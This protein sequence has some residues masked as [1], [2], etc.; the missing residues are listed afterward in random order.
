MPLR[1]DVWTHDSCLV[2]QSVHSTEEDKNKH[3][4]DASHKKKVVVYDF[5]SRELS[6]L[7]ASNQK[8]FLYER[9]YRANASVAGLDCICEL[10]FSWSAVPLWA[11]TICY[12]AGETLESADD[13]MHSSYHKRNYICEYHPDRYA[14]LLKVQ[15]KSAKNKQ[16]LLEQEAI[17]DTL[18][19]AKGLLSPDVYVLNGRSQEWAFQKLGLS[20]EPRKDPFIAEEVTDNHKI[21]LCYVCGETF[22]SFS[23]EEEFRDAWFSHLSTS[24]HQRCKAMQ[25]LVHEDNLVECEGVPAECEL[26]TNSEFRRFDDS[27]DDEANYGPTVGLDYLIIYNGT[28]CFCSL[29]FAILPKSS[30]T[31]H[32]S[33]EYHIE[34]FFRR[35]DP[36]KLLNTQY[37]SVS[38]RHGILEFCYG[39]LKLSSHKYFRSTS[40]IPILLQKYALQQRNALVKY[41]LEEVDFG[42]NLKAVWCEECKEYVNTVGDE[43]AWS[44]H[45]FDDSHFERAARRALYHYERSVVTRSCAALDN[46][47]HSYPPTWDEQ[48]SVSLG[49]LS[50]QNRCEFGLEFIIRDTLSSKLYCTC[51]F[52]QCDDN[53]TQMFSK[54][55][56]SLEHITRAMHSMNKKNM[57]TLSWRFPN[58]NDRKPLVM[59]YLVNCRKKLRQE[60]H[61][62]SVYNPALVYKMNCS[63]ALPK[64]LFKLAKIAPNDRITFIAEHKKRGQP[65]IVPLNNALNEFCR[66]EVKLEKK[67]VIVCHCEECSQS[68]SENF[69]KLD[70]AIAEH[71]LSLSH[72]ERKEIFNDNPF[73]ESQRI[74][75]R[76]SKIKVPPYK[77]PDPKKKVTWKWNDKKACYEFVYAQLGLEDIRERR[78]FGGETTDFFCTLCAQSFKA[79]KL[80]LECH[81]RSFSH[82]FYF[83]HK[84]RPAIIPELQ[85]QITAELEVAEKHKN[86]RRLFAR[87]LKGCETENNQCGIPIYDFEGRE[88]EYLDVKRALE[89]DRETEKNSDKRPKKETPAYEIYDLNVIYK[90]NNNPKWPNGEALD[91]YLTAIIEMC[92]EKNKDNRRETIVRPLEHAKRQLLDTVHFDGMVQL[93]DGAS[94]SAAVSNAPAVTV[95]PAVEKRQTV[96]TKAPTEKTKEASTPSRSTEV[97]ATPTA[98]VRQT[99]V[100]ENVSMGTS[101][102]RDSER[103]RRTRTPSPHRRSRRHS[104]SPVH[105]RKSSRHRIPEHRRSK[106]SKS[107]S[108]K[109]TRKERRNNE[110]SERPSSSRSKSV[111]RRPISRTS[112]SPDTYESA[113]KRL[114]DLKMKLATNETPRQFFPLPPMRKQLGSQSVSGAT[115]KDP[116]PPHRGPVPFPGYINIGGVYDAG[117]LEREYPDVLRTKTTPSD[118]H[119]TTT[120]E[121][122]VVAPSTDLTV[123]A[124]SSE[125]DRNVETTN[126][127]GASEDIRN[128]LM[129]RLKK[130]ANK[131]YKKIVMNIPKDLPA[132]KQQ[133]LMRQQTEKLKSNSPTKKADKKVAKTATLQQRQT[134]EQQE[135]ERLQTISPEPDDVIEVHSQQQ[136]QQQTGNGP[137]RQQQ[138]QRQQQIKTVNDLSK[139]KWDWVSGKFVPDNSTAVSQSAN[140]PLTNVP[141]ISPATAPPQGMPIP[142]IGLIAAPKLVETSTQQ[143]QN[144][145][146]QLGMST[147]A[148]RVFSGQ[149]PMA[150]AHAPISTPTV[151]MFRPPIPTVTVANLLGQ[152]PMPSFGA[153]PSI[154]SNLL[155]TLNSALGVPMAI[156]PVHFNQH[157]MPPLV[158]GFPSSMPPQQPPMMNPVEMILY[159]KM[160][161]YS[162]DLASIDNI[163]ALI[164]YM[165][166]QGYEPIPPGEPPLLFNEILSKRKGLIGANTLYQ[167]ICFGHPELETYYCGMCNHWTTVSEMFSHLRASMHRL[168]YMFRNYKMYHRKAM[169]EL[170]EER[171]D[172]MLERFASKIWDIEGCGRCTNRMRCIL[173]EEAIRRIWPDYISCVDNS[174]KIIDD[175]DDDLLMSQRV[176]PQKDFDQP[177][178]A[179]K[180]P[181]IGAELT[182]EQ[183][184]F[185]DHSVVRAASAQVRA[186]LVAKKL[187]LAER[188]GHPGIGLSSLNSDKRSE[189]ADKNV[190]NSKEK[191]RSQKES[192]V[193]KESNSNRSERRRDKSK[194]RSKQSST[195]KPKRSRSRERE[196]KKGE[197]D[198]ERER[199]RGG[200]R[201]SRSK[202][203]GTRTEEDKEKDSSRSKNSE[204]WMEK[205][206][207]FLH[208]IGDTKNA[209]KLY[210]E[211]TANEADEEPGRDDHQNMDKNVSTGGTKSASHSQTSSLADRLA[212]SSQSMVRRRGQIDEQERQQV[213]G[214]LSPEPPPMTTIRG[215]ERQRQLKRPAVDDKSEMRRAIAVMVELQQEYESN[216]GYLSA[217]MFF[218][219]CQAFNIAPDE[220]LNNRLLCET[221]NELGVDLRAGLRAFM[222]RNQQQQQQSTSQAAPGCQFNLQSMGVDPSKLRGLDPRALQSIL[223]KANTPKAPRTPASTT[224]LAP[225]PIR[226]RFEMHDIA[227]DESMA[228]GNYV[229]PSYEEG[230]DRHRQPQQQLQRH[231][232]S[233]ESNETLRQQEVGDDWNSLESF[234]FE[235]LGFGSGR[236]MEAPPR[237]NSA[238]AAVGHLPQPPS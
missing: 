100:A 4:L 56:R 49:V 123:E 150:N 52:V 102:P 118:V 137:Q 106:D 40:Q 132:F 217:D 18:L 127:V 92:T 32:F 90:R 140:T 33:S 180:T 206:A 82:L 2:C 76:E 54:H 5:L 21:A 121:S 36:G 227:L 212:S 134:E 205:A 229:Y 209:T 222:Q 80:D 171:R 215:T 125:S 172:L 232:P 186:S 104:R 7:T 203:R 159:S 202:D 130:D 3:E 200:R 35:D 155:G 109:R 24:I 131:D 141:A 66:I 126:Q 60:K 199:E 230:G 158:G 89:E 166:K 65:Q 204:S 94:Q 84:H 151:A 198:R 99:N 64:R 23:K 85:A 96:Q 110:F 188:A 48:F 6:C 13:H 69:D 211:A 196:G 128:Q 219:T 176:L 208:K 153:V 154:P 192:D 58:A 98:T 42:H 115:G 14:D 61:G 77:Q 143:A 174:W 111:N 63:S 189:E 29:C 233:Y 187:E 53:D 162:R 41:N 34:R 27:S 148:Q 197:R 114:D 213:Q 135:D 37:L 119:H 157:T 182:A 83:M 177:Q 12:V 173:N 116:S 136:Q 62:I 170:D 138:E 95:T 181:M 201:R 161:L 46:F 79:T 193:S 105:Q 124:I 194:E 145:L 101:K 45:I 224:A 25:I 142:K 146:S 26:R 39:E 163:A 70:N 78:H 17:V 149:Q 120:T 20:S 47:A 9:Y 210:W 97:E 71:L 91:K 93:E 68:F 19:E 184:I 183:I 178:L 226:S 191:K 179:Q 22:I 28:D 67:E 231:H 236:Q 11:C 51:C 160:Q 218:S 216:S 214:Q 38:E 117:F 50:I 220:V 55:A 30:I 234:S 72:W 235:M 59:D 107:P 112:R 44:I 156:P 223:S 168:S 103:R 113:K 10:N 31:N 73:D 221:A 147:S 152:Q 87:S 207:Q 237:Q 165:W 74:P 1:Q 16:S 164:E 75:D 57:I 8:S 167:I 190:T 195:E 81:I 228:P 86:I 225:S 139:S 88:C 169:E 129:N 15:E 43:N 122:Q 175:D 133:A 108:P 238:S 144:L 185:T